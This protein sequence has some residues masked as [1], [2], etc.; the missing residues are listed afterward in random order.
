MFLKIIDVLYY[1]Y[2]FYVLLINYYAMYYNYE[3]YVH[4][5]FLC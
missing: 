4:L 3:P 2:Y 1:I 5:N